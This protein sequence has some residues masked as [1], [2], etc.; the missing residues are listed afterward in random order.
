MDGKGPRHLLDQ[1]G[2]DLVIDCGVGG[3]ESNFDSITLNVLPNSSRSAHQ[4][5]PPKDAESQS[6]MADEAQRLADAREVYREIRDKNGCGHIELAGRTVGCPFVG[7]VAAT[8][9]VSELLRRT[10]GAK[11][12]DYLRIQ[13]SSPQDL[14]TRDSTSIKNVRIPFQT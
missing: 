4:I 8:L 3:S 11:Q 7:A 5:W 6:R 12:F 14:I 2:F 10:A 1:C 13:L 9:V